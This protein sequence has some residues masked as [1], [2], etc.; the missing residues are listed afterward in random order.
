MLTP[1]STKQN[2]TKIYKT[3]H[4]IFSFLK[5]SSIHVYIGGGYPV[6]LGCLVAHRLH[7]PS[8]DN[9]NC[10]QT[11]QMF[12]QVGEGGRIILG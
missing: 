7:F 2:N 11:C 5:N 9:Q 6:H 12:W 8:C 1:L 3:R 4:V 10:L